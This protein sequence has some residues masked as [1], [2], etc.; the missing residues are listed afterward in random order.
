MAPGGTPILSFV[1]QPGRQYR[2]QRR[3]DFDA[4]SWLNLGGAPVTGAGTV[5]VVDVP[6]YPATSFYR[7]VMVP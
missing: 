6:P 7:V 3:T 5:S 2:L 1:A 4:G